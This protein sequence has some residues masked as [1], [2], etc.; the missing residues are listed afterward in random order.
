VAAVTYS[1]TI[2]TARTGSRE[3]RCAEDGA[4]L[5]TDQLIPLYRVASSPRN[6]RP[7]FPVKIHSRRH[8]G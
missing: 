6:S 5:V 2:E 4:D 7:S 3:G 8:H 1:I